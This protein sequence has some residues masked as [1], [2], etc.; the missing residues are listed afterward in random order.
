MTDDGAFCTELPGPTRWLLCSVG[1]GRCALPLDHVIEIMRL[2]PIERVAAAPPFILGLSIIR[3]QPMPVVHLGI[4]LGETAGEPAR[5]ISATIGG[6]PV[7]LAVDAVSGV[8]SIDPT[9]LND[10]PPL[11]RNAA[12]DA[13]MAIGTLDAE[14]LFL[15]QVGRL[16]PETVFVLLGAEAAT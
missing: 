12:S 2:L 11:L 3:G 13:V 14:L 7:A 1:P 16:V 15:L 5:L 6:R 4:L 8:R 10:L 9:L